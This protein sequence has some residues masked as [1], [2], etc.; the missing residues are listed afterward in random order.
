MP[1]KVGEKTKNGWPILKHEDDKWIVV[2]YSQTKENAQASIRA[3]YM[4]EHD[5]K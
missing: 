5:K 4:H 2:G 1:Y 3:R